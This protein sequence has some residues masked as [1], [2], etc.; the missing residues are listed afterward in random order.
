MLGDSMSG[1]LFYFRPGEEARMLARCQF[2]VDKEGR[3]GATFTYPIKGYPWRRNVVR[4]F[5]FQVGEDTKAMLF[6][7]VRRIREEHPEECLANDQLWSDQSEKANGITRDKLGGKLCYTIAIIR[8]DGGYEEYFA[9][10]EDS[11]A[12]LTSSLY[13]II[14]RLIEPYEKL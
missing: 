10:R 5:E 14:S 4:S 9:M 11:K 8:E 3:C 13:K 1:H 6:A 2:G 12:L 7:E